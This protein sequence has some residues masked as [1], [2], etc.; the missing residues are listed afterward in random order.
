MKIQLIDSLLQFIAHD[1]AWPYHTPRNNK[2]KTEQNERQSA[3]IRTQFWGASSATV[4][5]SAKQ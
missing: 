5:Y 2:R 4:D 3:E 1:A